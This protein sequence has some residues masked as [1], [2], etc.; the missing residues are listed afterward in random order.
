[1]FLELLGGCASLYSKVSAWYVFTAARTLK[2]S[3]PLVS[4]L[5]MG[6]PAN[7]TRYNSYSNVLYFTLLDQLTF[8]LKL[9]RTVWV[10]I[11]VGMA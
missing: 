5:V 7:V 3:N 1:M 4:N 9:F 11:S 2:R 8:S 6:A 10:L